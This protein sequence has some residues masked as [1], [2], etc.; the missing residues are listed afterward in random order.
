[1]H[2]LLHLEPKKEK[3]FKKLRL[4][5]LFIVVVLNIII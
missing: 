3:V 5:I 2:I 4:K 1:M